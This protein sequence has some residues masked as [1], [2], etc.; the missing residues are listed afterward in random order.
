[1]TRVF[2]FCFLAIIS[3]ETW[4]GNNLVLE[5]L[6]EEDQAD[7]REIGN[8]GKIPDIKV[9]LGRRSKIFDL[10]LEGEI[11]NGEDYIRALIILQHTSLWFYTDE[12]MLSI[13]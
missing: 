3:F 8:G 6:Y 12:L 7:R 10:L 2:F 11:V 9:D 4:A 13:S 1:M 5:A